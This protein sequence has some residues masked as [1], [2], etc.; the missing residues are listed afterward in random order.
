MNLPARLENAP[1]LLEELQLACPSREQLYAVKGEKGNVEAVVIEFQVEGIH[2][3]EV[4][5][6]VGQSG[7]FASGADHRFAQVNSDDIETHLGE[8]DRR[9]PSP[10]ADI[11]DSR[12]VWNVIE[13]EYFLGR[14]QADR[15]VPGNDGGIFVAGSDELPYSRL[16]MTGGIGIR[17]RPSA[18]GHLG[19]QPRSLDDL[20]EA[21]EEASAHGAVDSA[22]ISSQIDGHIRPHGKG[23]IFECDNAFFDCTDS[24]NRDLRWIDDGGESRHAEHPEIGN[25][26][27]AAG[28]LV[29]SETTLP[30][31]IHEPRRFLGDLLNRKIRHIL[32]N[33]HEKPLRRISGDSDIDVSE[34]S[35]GPVFVDPVEP[36]KL[37]ESPRHRFHHEVVVGNFL[38]LE[39]VPL[40]KLLKPDPGDLHPHMYMRN[41]SG[42]SR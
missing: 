32:Q 24:Q 16:A 42:S 4:Y 6:D 10:A 31:A 39:A 26:E 7:L 8:R 35:N 30:G 13:N 29:E 27:R 2:H 41:V 17:R 34:L 15:H 3:L 12:V 36:W 20:F 1:D 22:M 21:S 18:P 9:T 5:F 33:R 19:E 23:I 25:R 37:G 28:Q 38:A 11:E 40:T 14:P